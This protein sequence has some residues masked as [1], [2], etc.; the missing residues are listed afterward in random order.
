[1]AI[2]YSYPTV[3][4]TTSDLILGTDTSTT[5]QATKNFTVQSI[6][7]LF[8]VVGNDLQAVLD[9]GNV[10]TG[11]DIILGSEAVPDRTVHAGT[12]TTGP[13]S[14]VIVGAV[15]IGFTD[16]TSTRITGALISTGAAA[17]IASGVQAVTQN[18]GDNS[19]KIATTA[20]VDSIVDP[21]ILTFAGTTGGDQTV[22]LVAQKLSL[23]GT[24]NQIE[25]VSTGQS[26]TFNFPTAGVTLPDGSL[27]TTQALT[28]TTTKVA[29]TAFVHGKTMRK[30]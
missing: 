11:R 13:G 20:Y 27:A 12:F 18:A 23:L 25:S 16:F 8:T 5:N 1:M 21:S 7:D 4:P 15:G 3:V 6:L 28:D 30:I 14:A 24:A 22:N 26:I 29:T 10:A 9:F 19:T 17:Q 2:I